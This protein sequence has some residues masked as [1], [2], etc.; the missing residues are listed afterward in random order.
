MSLAGSYVV[1]QINPKA[2]VAEFGDGPI[3]ALAKA[4]GAGK[5]VGLIDKVRSA[6]LLPQPLRDEGWSR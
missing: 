2:M 3:Y 5:F 6:S 1:L 4:L